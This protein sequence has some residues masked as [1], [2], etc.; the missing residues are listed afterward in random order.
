MKKVLILGVAAVQY[1]AI[2]NLKDKGYTVH[3]L[4]RSNDG[5]GADLADTFTEIDILDL[6]T[7]EEYIVANQ[8]D[9]VYSVGSDIA[10]PV[11]S[12]LSEKLNLPHFVS[13]NTARTCNNKNQMRETLGSGFSGNIEFKVL[14]EFEE[15]TNLTYPFIVKPTDSQGQRGVSLVSN[16][17]E[18]KTAYETAK[19]ASRS[20]LVI[21]EQYVNGPEVSVN[22][23]LIDGELKFFAVSDRDT[24]PQ[25]TGLIHKHILP[26]KKAD[27][28]VQ[29]KIRDVLEAISNKMGIYN[30]PVYAQMKI[31]KDNPYLIEITPRLDGCHMWN[32]IHKNSQINLLELTFEHL[33]HNNTEEINEVQIDE[34]T[35][36]LEFIC[37]TPNEEAEYSGYKTQLTDSL[38]SF[39]YYNEK[40]MIRPI[41]GKHEKIGYFI[42]K[43]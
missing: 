29:K 27:K 32:I 11:V 16:L 23:Y 19:S 42:Y 1:D 31:E 9:A 39:Q 28:E 3:A 37:Q 4:A 26:S 12:Y 40:D 25:Y 5:P 34:A 41:N 38:D 10:M 33:L 8:I 2:K 22:G 18:F 15:P 43:K 13:E 17:E 14:S 30:G 21:T 35:H 7:V 36:I 6:E 24:W 20:G